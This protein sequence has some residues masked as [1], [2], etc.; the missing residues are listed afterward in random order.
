MH[1]PTAFDLNASTSCLAEERPVWQHI[2]ITYRA[3][4]MRIKAG[5]KRGV[6]LPPQLAL[7]NSHDIAG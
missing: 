5:E 4:Q 1:Y 2:R 3:L 7:G 6:S